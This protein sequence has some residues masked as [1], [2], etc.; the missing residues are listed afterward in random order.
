MMEFV[1]KEVKSRKKKHNLGGEHQHELSQRAL[2][3][4]NWLDHGT[5]TKIK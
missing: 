3:F 2:K 1:S 5:K 4:I